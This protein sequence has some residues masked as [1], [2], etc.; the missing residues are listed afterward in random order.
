MVSGLQEFQREQVKDNEPIRK[1]LEVLDD[2]LAENRA[3]LRRLLDLYLAGD[4]PKEML[5]DRKSR[6]EEIIDAL[7]REWTGLSAQLEIEAISEEEIQSL[8]DFAAEVSEG[9]EQAEEHFETR[10][11]IIEELDVQVTLSVEDGQRVLYARC[12]LGEHFC[13]VR[14]G[15]AA[16]SR[17]KESKHVDCHRGSGID[18]AVPMAH[19]GGSPGCG[20]GL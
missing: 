20:C 18:G 3:Q 8:R 19:H 16:F 1:R 10:R 7:E 13:T 4:F 9:L 6:L 2:L 15:R 11:R 5:I 17:R 14:S 12:M